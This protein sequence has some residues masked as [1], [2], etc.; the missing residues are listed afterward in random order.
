MVNRDQKY[1][2]NILHPESNYTPSIYTKK[3]VPNL[4][5]TEYIWKKAGYESKY[6][7]SL[8]DYPAKAN[9]PIYYSDIED[10]KLPNSAISKL[11]I[12][13]SMYGHPRNEMSMAYNERDRS[14]CPAMHTKKFLHMAITFV[15]PVICI[16]GSQP[17]KGGT[18]L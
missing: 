13:G 16:A 2:H 18:T 9:S 14:A 8:E 10:R 11:K 3:N 5:T 4:T 15:R 17:Q 12:Q 7:P 1:F 6:R